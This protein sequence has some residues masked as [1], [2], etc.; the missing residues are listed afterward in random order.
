M[1]SHG[2]FYGERILLRGEIRTAF[3]SSTAGT[4]QR[5]FDTSVRKHFVKI[6]AVYVGKQAEEL[7]DSGYRLTGA[8]QCPEEY[9][10][11]R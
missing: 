2:R 5:A 4:L 7:L 1:L 3:K 10:L 6:K 8:E 11:T 9:D